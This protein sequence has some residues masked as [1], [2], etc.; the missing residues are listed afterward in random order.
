MKRKMGKKEEINKK[1]IVKK[2]TIL[3]KEKISEK[4]LPLIKE[5]IAKPRFNFNLV[6]GIMIFILLIGA[7]FSISIVFGIAF[8]LCFI[9]SIYNK[10]LEKK[11][12][13]P[14]ILFLIGLIIRIIF[15]WFLPSV[16]EIIIYLDLIISLIILVIIFLMSF[17]IRKK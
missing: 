1:K 8:S 4:E 15:L 9:V 14:L 7:S 13:L 2:K 5:D 10:I 3:K 11:P 16:F 17:K 12:F 6:T